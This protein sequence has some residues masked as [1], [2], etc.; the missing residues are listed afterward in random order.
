M[1]QRSVRA[2]ED[3]VA[4]HP[5]QAVAIVSHADPIKAIL[6]HYAGVHL[7]GFQRFAVAPA[8]LSVLDVGP[9]GAVVLRVNDTGTTTDLA[10][11]APGSEPG[12]ADR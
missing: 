9:A 2:V 1:Q 3:V 8:S 7:D 6:A 10:P 12:G 5:G 11:A 4:S